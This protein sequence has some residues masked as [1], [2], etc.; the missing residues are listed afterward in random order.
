MVGQVGFEPTQYKDNGFTVRR[1]S[2]TSPLPVIG[3]ERRTRTFDTRALCIIILQFKAFAS[4]IFFTLLY[5]LSYLPKLLPGVGLE[6]TTTEL[7]AQIDK[8]AVR[9]FHKIRCLILRALSTELPWHIKLYRRWIVGFEPTVAALFFTKYCC[10]CLTRHLVFWAA[11][12]PLDHIHH[13]N[14]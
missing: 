5:Q 6:P 12:L 7:T 2:P 4:L 8:I 13:I 1:D 3:R 10:Q 14:W 11:V 9:T